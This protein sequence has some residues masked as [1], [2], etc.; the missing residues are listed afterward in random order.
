MNTEDNSAGP[1]DSTP[2]PAPNPFHRSLQIRVPRTATQRVDDGATWSMNSHDGASRT[3]GVSRVQ[4]SDLV[5]MNAGVLAS[6]RTR[7]GGGP[8]HRITENTVVRVNGHDMAV[9]T[10]VQLGALRRTGTGEYEETGRGIGGRPTSQPVPLE[11]PPAHTPQP[12]EANAVSATETL[13]AALPAP[14]LNRVIESVITKGRGAPAVTHL[15]SDLGIDAAS[16]H[17][18]VS[19]AVDGFQRQADEIVAGMG[20]EPAHFYEWART[21]HRD[22]LRN[23]MREHFHGIGLESYVVL[24]DKYARKVAPDAETLRQGGLRT[25]Y[26]RN[27]HE[28][29]VTVKGVTMSVKAAAKTGLI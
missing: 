7:S 10:A 12:L 22:E 27:T 11:L 3:E 9:K 8:A 25:F 1:G 28:Q 2:A 21:N 4:T 18:T 19:T 6:A 26:D 20:L 29:M 24:A 23:A 5:N 17:A 15:A 16:L 14:V 13:R